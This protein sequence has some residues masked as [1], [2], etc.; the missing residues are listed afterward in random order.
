MGRFLA[1]LAAGLAFGLG[2]SVVLWLIVA[3]VTLNLQWTADE[4]DARGMRGFFV[5]FSIIGIGLSFSPDQA[6][7]EGGKP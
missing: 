2:V 5:I 1:K 3:F 6:P 4:W 7:T